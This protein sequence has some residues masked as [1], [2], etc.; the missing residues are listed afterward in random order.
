MNYC[1]D[2]L[3][4]IDIF[5]NMF[6]M[7]YD[8]ANKFWEERI[9]HIIQHYAKSWMLID[10]LCIFPFD[11]VTRS[12][13]T[14]LIRML[15]F[16]RIIKMVRAIKASTIV[17]R[18]FVRYEINQDFFKIVRNIITI[19]V[20]FHLIVCIWK[21]LGSETDPE[22]WIMLNGLVKGEGDNAEL[23]TPDMYYITIIQ[24]VMFVGELDLMLSS[25]RFLFIVSTLVVYA[26]AAVFFA[27]IMDL[28]AN[29][30]EET[31]KFKNFMSDLNEFM[32]DNNFPQTLRESMREYFQYRH[33]T[34]EGE[35]QVAERTTLLKSLSPKLLEEVGIHM[36]RQGMGRVHLFRDVRTDVM[37]KF[38][39]ATHTNVYISHESI[40][41]AGHP[42]GRVYMLMKGAL[43]CDGRMVKDGD[44]CGEVSLL[45]RQTLYT[46][47]VVTTMYSSVSYIS[48]EAVET[49]LVDFPCE[50]KRMRRKVLRSIGRK[51]ILFYA[52]MGRRQMGLFTPFDRYFT[53][54]VPESRMYA[55]WATFAYLN[56]S[57]MEMEIAA[58][59]IQRQFRNLRIARLLKLSLYKIKTQVSFRHHHINMEL[60][61]LKKSDAKL[62]QHMLVNELRRQKARA[63]KGLKMCVERLYEKHTGQDEMD[64]VDKRLALLESDLFDFREE[65]HERMESMAEKH[66]SFEGMMR[67][68]YFGI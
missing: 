10:V 31:T 16:L 35:T 1:V 38:T 8:E 37:V 62:V 46:D 33:G 25:E 54:T 30:N 6:T 22:S 14:S 52:Y 57:A 49:I 68:H 65:T 67:K 63:R 24:L 40:Y 23:P 5:V 11:L 45:S 59:R 55:S 56:G 36:S 27:E 21:G 17:S 9:P 66:G 48:R 18:V 39:L 2:F 43:M 7:Y 64:S 34:G 41:S 58:L 61:N 60:E 28:I 15:K 32:R 50:Q 51:A 44:V 3:F 53:A 20:S 47:S 29:L 13:Q 42:A 12:S 19:L 26:L 4:L